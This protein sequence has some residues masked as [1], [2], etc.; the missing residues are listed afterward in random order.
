[1]FRRARST[2]AVAPAII[3]LAIATLMSGCAASSSAE[4]RDGNHSPTS[5]VATS[6]A[7]S[8]DLR[9]I[10]A[11]T[12]KAIDAYN[13][14]NLTALKSISCG[15]L[16]TD[17]A[18]TTTRDFRDESRADLRRRGTG[19]VVSISELKTLNTHATGNVVVQYQRQVAGLDAQNRIHFEGTYK[20]VKGTWRICGVD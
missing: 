8:D 2:I 15:A 18:K 17:L 6:V 14:G 13:T 3:I 10:T 11:V 16:K 7:P 4:R 1:M 20:R 19:T 5:S 9:E 12:R